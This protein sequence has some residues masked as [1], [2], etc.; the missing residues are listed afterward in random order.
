M[1][2]SV[3]IRTKNEGKWLRTLLKSLELQSTP[4]DEIIIVDSGSTDNT[5]SIINNFNCVLIN[6]DDHV[7]NYSKSLN[8]GIER[9][10]NDCITM[11]SGHS[12]PF[13]R[14]LVENGSKLLYSDPNIAGVGGFMYPLFDAP[15]HEQIEG[16]Y[17]RLSHEQAGTLNHNPNLSNTNSMIKKSFWEKYRFDESLLEGCEDYDWAKYWIHNGYNIVKN[18][19]LDIFHSHWHVPG[20]I[21]WDDQVKIWKKTTDL[22]DLRYA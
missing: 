21:S 2:T 3:I 4:P 16:Y 10:E 19:V 1:K 7:F 9:A 22:I 11:L 14:Y 13:D 18:P 15:K 6:A 12:L 17:R 8:I 20:Y 5:L